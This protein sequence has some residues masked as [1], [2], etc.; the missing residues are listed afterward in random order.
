MSVPIEPAAPQAPNAEIT[1]KGR[2]WVVRIGALAAVVVLLGM[3]APLVVSAALAGAGL[4]ALGVSG[5]AVFALIQALPLLGQR[6]ENRLLAARRREA[7]RNPIEQMHNELLRRAEQ[8]RSFRTALA[9]VQAQIAGLQDMLDTRRQQTPGHDLRKTESVLARMR[10]VYASHVDRLASAES[11]L[12]DFDRHVS[13]KRFEYQCALELE[14]INHAL[15]GSDSTRM[16]EQML[17]DEATQA[18]Q[19]R[20]N[21]AFAALELDHQLML[22]SRP[23]ASQGFDLVNQADWPVASPNGRRH[24]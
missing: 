23:M 6:L 17:S 1:E 9:G 11:A 14:Q 15:H 2:S 20:F 12:Q 19:Q 18:V 10:S 24:P 5:L 7:R 21:Q 16:L 8:I 4:V 3:A 22:Q 13:A